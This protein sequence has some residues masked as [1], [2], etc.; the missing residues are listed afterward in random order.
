MSNFLKKLEERV[1]KGSPVFIAPNAT[2]IGDVELGDFSSVWFQAVIRADMGRVLVGK[3][4]NIQDGVIIHTDPGLDVNIGESCV[5]G[6]GAVLHGCSIGD[7]SLVGIRATILNQAVIGKG[8][9][10]GANALVTE[11]MVIPDYS[12]VLGSPGKV[13][14]TL[15]PEII[16]QIKLGAD[17]YVEEMKM[18]LS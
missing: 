16:E 1:K 3:R 18:F 12:M 9:I 13:V 11:R 2:V 10:I 15:N 5:I 7:F 8:C 14:K 4:T 6:H 17:A